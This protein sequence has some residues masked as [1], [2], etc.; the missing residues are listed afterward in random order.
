MYTHTHNIYIY[1]DTYRVSHNIYIRIYIH[2]YAYIHAYVLQMQRYKR[3][4]AGVAA[5]GESRRL[6]HAALRSLV[7]VALSY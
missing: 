6:V 3:E 5:A 1:I 4:R 7:Y 2:T